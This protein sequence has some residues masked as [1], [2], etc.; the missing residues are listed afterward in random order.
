MKMLDFIKR[1]FGVTVAEKP[2]CSRSERW[3]RELEGW[4][5]VPLFWPAASI[6]RCSCR[7]CRN[8]AYLI[9]PMS[10]RGKEIFDS[11][12]ALA[13]KQSET[14]ADYI[15]NAEVFAKGRWE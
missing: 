6:L 2:S 7:Q 10:I 5:R 12:I 1:L 14:L 4:D 13:K 8:S 15:K 11:H 9:Y 3:W